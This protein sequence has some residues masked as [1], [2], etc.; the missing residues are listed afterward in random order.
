VRSKWL[1]LLPKSIRNVI[2][3]S[4]VIAHFGQEDLRLLLMSGA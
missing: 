3:Q 1:N 4:L 2:F